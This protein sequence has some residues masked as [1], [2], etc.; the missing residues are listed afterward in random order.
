[1]DELGKSF[2]AAEGMVDAEQ[3]GSSKRHNENCLNCSTKLTDI[4]LTTMVTK[5]IC[6]L[7]TAV[8]AVFIVTFRAARLLG[9]HHALRCRK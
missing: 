8:Q 7:G 6:Q 3:S 9:I 4:F 1:M 5:D 2:P